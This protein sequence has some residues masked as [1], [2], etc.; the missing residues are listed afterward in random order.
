MQSHSQ[1]IHSSFIRSLSCRNEWKN[2]SVME[3][4][5]LIAVQSHFHGF[6]VV[7]NIH[8]ES[9]KMLPPAF[10]SG[11][12]TLSHNYLDKMDKYANLYILNDYKN[13]WRRWMDEDDDEGDCFKGVCKSQLHSCLIW[14][15]K[16]SC[17]HVYQCVI[18][19]RCCLR[20]ITSCKL[21][22][23]Y[24]LSVSNLNHGGLIDVFLTCPVRDE[25]VVSL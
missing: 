3:T 21:S 7:Q 13:W 8:T 25:H 23:G 20:Y 9:T 1:E 6:C 18:C 14:S 12:L 11:K 4:W 2:C 24:L 17:V 15:E 22:C 10:T 5:V 19:W 16:S